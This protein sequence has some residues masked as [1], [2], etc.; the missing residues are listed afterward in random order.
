M[1]I[2]DAVPTDFDDITAI[3]NEIL[4]SSTAIY[5]DTPATC[6]D[7]LAWRNARLAQGYPVLVAEDANRIAGTP[8]SQT[9]APGPATNSR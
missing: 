8:P 3:Y 7:R 6:Q 2:R 4:T 5:S 1:R 9:S